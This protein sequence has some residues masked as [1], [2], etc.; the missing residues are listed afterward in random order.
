MTKT[1]TKCGAEKWLELFHKSAKTKDGLTYWCK[2]CHSAYY[3]ARVKGDPQYFLKYQRL[4]RNNKRAKTVALRVG[5][6]CADC[7]EKHPACL[8]FHHIDPS[9]KDDGVMALVDQNARWPRIEA[10]IAKC[11]VL[12][13]NCHRK[14]HY[15]D[16]NA[17]A[18]SVA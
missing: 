11:V 5:K 2:S 7:G 17:A 3:A 9:R 6:G 4:S 8:E 10:E 18:E 1:C 13:S 12:C 15:N 16:K 14:R